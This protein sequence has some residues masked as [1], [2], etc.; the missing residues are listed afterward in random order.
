MEASHICKSQELKDSVLANRN[1][2]PFT[3]SHGWVLFVEWL[4]ILILLTVYS[5]V[6]FKTSVVFWNLQFLIYLLPFS[7]KVDKSTRWKNRFS[8]IWKPTR[9]HW[10]LW[11]QYFFH[12][13][14]FMET[15]IVKR[16]IL[17]IIFIF[18]SF[19]KLTQYIALKSLP[20]NDHKVCESSCNH[21]H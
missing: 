3:F 19:K 10:K 4:P 13:F 11:H 8:Q 6:A 5:D 14:H 17:A 21:V 20:W 15:I 18:N 16:Q 2:L 7:I 1:G 9:T 12:N